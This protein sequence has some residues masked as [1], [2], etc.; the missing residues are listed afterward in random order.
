VATPEKELR[1]T[2]EL[3]L[4]GKQ[5]NYALAAILGLGGYGVYSIDGNG[6]EVRRLDEQFVIATNDKIKALEIEISSI[7]KDL[8]RIAVS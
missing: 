5:I 2:L 6:Q 3:N 8:Q 1:A 4:S 7:R